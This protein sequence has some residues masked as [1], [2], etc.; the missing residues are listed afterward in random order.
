MKIAIK[1]QIKE[2]NLQ[3]EKSSTTCYQTKSHHQSM[4]HKHIITTAEQIND[5]IGRIRGGAGGVEE[6]GPGRHKPLPLG[7]ARAV[8]S[9]GEEA[10]VAVDLGGGRRGGGAGE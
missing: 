10:R 4:C 3:Q 1:L 5:G 2:T 7:E 9:S 6:H 8:D